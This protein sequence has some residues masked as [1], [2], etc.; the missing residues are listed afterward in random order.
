MV[1]SKEA[2]SM[3]KVPMVFRRCR[4]AVLLAVVAI[5]AGPARAGDW[6]GYMNVWT[7]PQSAGGSYLFGSPWGLP[8]VKTVVI[9]GSGT[10]TNITNNILD[11]YPNYNAYADNPGN[12]FWRNNGGAGPRGNKWMEAN[13]YVESTVATDTAVFSGTVSAYSLASEFRAEAFIKLFDSN[14]NLVGTQSQPLT[15][16][17]NFSLSL[18]TFF[19]QGYRVQSGFMV[20]GTN[21][22]PA[23]AVA[24]GSF[25]VI[26]QPSGGS[27]IL[28]NVGS[29]TTRTQAQAGYPSIP[30]AIFRCIRFMTSRTGGASATGRVA[31]VIRSVRI[32]ADT[33]RSPTNTRPSRKAIASDSAKS[34]RPM[35]SSSGT[36]RSSATS[37]TARYIAPVSM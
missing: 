3:V 5:A 15:G 27:V 10:G 35:A 18:D 6:K 29:G 12:S 17:G 23:A 32:S 28:I 8:D 11:L 33:S 30:S 36:P 24:N 4:W 13:T 9:N 1:L 34:A 22:N 26:T 2:V 16:Q 31:A 37:V 7:A 19:Y 14:Y 25:Q 20:S 21:A